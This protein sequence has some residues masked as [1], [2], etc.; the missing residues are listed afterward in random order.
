MTL[1]L[2]MGDHGSG[3]A[4]GPSSFSGQY[5]GTCSSRRPRACV[6]FV[7]GL[8]RAPC[9]SLCPSFSSRRYRVQSEGRAPAWHRPTD[10]TLSMMQTTFE[11]GN[12]WIARP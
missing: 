5:R 9:G 8:A 1:L 2:V 11:A 6:P 4:P 7:R 3:G 10:Q 12:W